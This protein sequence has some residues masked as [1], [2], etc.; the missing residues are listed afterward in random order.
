MKKIAYIALFGFLGVLVSTLLHAVIEL[1]VLHFLLTDFSQYNLGMSW[2]QWFT[3]HFW[4]SIVL[5]LLGI[6]IGI[7]QGVYWWQRLYG[8]DSKR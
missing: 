6:G 4:G 5:L 7:W 2:S 3:V 8:S 1:K